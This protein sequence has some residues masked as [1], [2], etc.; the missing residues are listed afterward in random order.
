[1]AQTLPSNPG[2]YWVLHNSTKQTVPAFLT[3]VNP[4][5]SMERAGYELVAR[6]RVASAGLEHQVGIAPNID[7]T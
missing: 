4:F 1:M 5:M 3:T 6:V 7:C 2:L